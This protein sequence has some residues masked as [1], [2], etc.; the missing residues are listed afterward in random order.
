MCIGVPLLLCSRSCGDHQQDQKQRASCPSDSKTLFDSPT[1]RHKNQMAGVVAIGEKVRKKEAI[2]TLVEEISRGEEESLAPSLRSGLENGWGQQFYEILKLSQ[3]K[4]EKEIDK[5]CSRHYFDFLHAVQE[6]LTMRDTAHDI[7]DSITEVHSFLSEISQN[8]F[9]ELKKLETLQFEKENSQQSLQEMIYCQQITALVVQTKKAIQGKDFYGALNTLEILVEELSSA[10]VSQ[11]RPFVALV[12]RWIHELTDEILTASKVDLQV[13]FNEVK[14]K[15]EM[16]G[17][18]IMHLC[19]DSF[20]T[21]T[22]QR[23][24]ATRGDGDDSDDTSDDDLYHHTPSSRHHHRSGGV[25]FDGPISMSLEMIRSLSDTSH[26]DFL[27]YCE[28]E[29]EQTIPVDFNSAIPSDG[30]RSLDTLTESLSPLHKAFF[31]HHRLHRLSELHQIY[32][33]NRELLITH[34]LINPSAAGLVAHE[35]K[36][37]KHGFENVFPDLLYTVCGFFTIES[38]IRRSIVMTP[39][40]S[41]TVTVLSK[42]GVAGGGGGGS[43]S[44]P[45]GGE[46]E[47][48]TESN[49]ER[50]GEGGG[51]GG[52]NSV[53]VTS[54]SAGGPSAPTLLSVFSWNQLKDL[55]LI[56]CGQIKEFCAKYAKTILTTHAMLQVKEE[57]LLA[58]ETLSDELI[59]FRDHSLMET[60]NILWGRFNTLQ[61][62]EMKER[63]SEAWRESGYQPFYVQ[64][65]VQQEEEI[66]PF[67]LDKLHFSLD[68]YYSELLN[69]AT[70]GGQ[71]TA[72]LMTSF[73]HTTTSTSSSASSPS[74]SQSHPH[75]PHSLAYLDMLED[76]QMELMSQPH[77]NGDGGGGR[78]RGLSIGT[79]KTHDTQTST[80]MAMTSPTAF[81][82]YT[83]PFSAGVTKILKHFNFT[84]IKYLQYTVH[85]EYASYTS[86]TTFYQTIHT[87]LTHITTFLQSEITPSPSGGGGGG[88]SSSVGVQFDDLP[89]S[90]LC[91]VSI[92]SI[93]LM[94]CCDKYLHEILYHFLLHVN[95]IESMEQ[96]LEQI[97]CDIKLRLSQIS[98]LAYDLIFELITLKISDLLTSLIFISTLPNILILSSSSTG[99]S[100]GG[101]GSSNT[102]SVEGH[103]CI[104]EIIQY[105]E[106]TF[107]SFTYLPQNIRESLYFISCSKINS[108]LL[109]YFLSSSSSSS[110]SSA[111]ASRGVSSWNML[112]IKTFQQDYKLLDSFADSSGVTQL[113]ECFNEGRNLINALLSFELCNI[114]DTS[115]AMRTAQFSVLDLNKL[116]TL[117]EKV[118][119]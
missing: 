11:L 86:S 39:S 41:T 81:H 92:D 90:K 5:I 57:L 67:Y 70:G 114:G 23:A 82:S 48:E 8:L 54:G 43:S 63:C 91:Q 12:Q 44:T 65:F 110:A 4:R 108:L 20:I 56:A 34:T 107:L 71:A 103:E 113:K 37:L 58:S 21:E 59:G 84:V 74:R 117:F 99:T 42:S 115:Q 105:L 49:G 31:M 95:W 119:A 19:A 106:I 45:G 118:R 62:E 52:G 112:C 109:D 13:W 22:L 64:H 69:Q 27:D 85:N 10:S 24:R 18:T 76:E 88:G 46:N 16:I 73:H 2:E 53:G 35:T 87:I 100:G 116:V 28:S 111:S 97:L 51:R 50:G 60:L 15:N 80:T 61:A 55:W 6:L 98:S 77:D 26:W 47:D 89:L 40:S 104:H 66:R 38:I 9:S 14:S 72:S 7:S 83:A 68:T 94:Y 29:V 96:S 1:E 102:S 36:I 30:K 25:E 78:V 17:A 75:N 3:N 79:S 32:C 101:G 93:T 33:E